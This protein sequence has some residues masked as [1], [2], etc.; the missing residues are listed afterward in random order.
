ML[1]RGLV[2]LA[3]GAAAANALPPRTEEAFHA[4]EV[5]NSSSIILRGR[6]LGLAL[7]SVDLLMRLL[8]ILMLQ[9]ATVVSKALLRSVLP[10]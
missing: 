3:V 4:V 6:L 9:L 1:G 10:V 8:M 2:E 5:A 7:S